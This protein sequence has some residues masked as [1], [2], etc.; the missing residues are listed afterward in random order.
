M[1]RIKFKPTL[2]EQRQ[3]VDAALRWQ[4][5]LSGRPVPPE[6]LNNVAPKRER[7]APRQLEAPVVAAISELLARHPKVLWMLRVNAGMA[8]Y[9]AKSGKWAPVHFHRWL[10]SPSPMRMPDFYGMLV[11]GRSIA[12]EAKKPTWQKPTDQREREQADFLLCIRERGGIGA[13]VTSADQ[14]SEI[15]KLC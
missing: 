2:R 5:A 11:D 9:E 3:N 7:A 10:R 8:S 13:F 12:L 15:L 1:A 4:A 6:L 14:V